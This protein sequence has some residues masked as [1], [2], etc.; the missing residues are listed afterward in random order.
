MR[1]IFFI[2]IT[3]ILVSSLN[4]AEMK[5]KLRSD[6]M[7]TQPQTIFKKNLESNLKLDLPPVAAN[8]PGSEMLKMWLVGVM[9]DVSFPT[10]DLGDAY[11]TGFSGH[12]M[13]GYMIARS[14]LLNLSV[15]YTSFS[16]KESVEG[17][18]I[19]FSWVPL[20]LGVNYVFNP[21]KKFMPFIG[22]ALGLYFISQ[23][24]SYSGFGQTFEADD[25]STEF[26]IV[27]RIGAYYVASASV[28]LALSLEYNII[29]TEGSSSSALGILFG[30][31]F[32]F[33]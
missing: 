9:A 14:V 21:D 11:S 23:S 31:M 18:D 17:A 1:Q 33:H 4:M 10:G 24:F 26:G 7:E 12:A 27:P 3:V 15:G 30:A 5:L 13:L 22:A 6:L 29:F 28:L 19:S 16:E 2:L 8:Q 32:A 25:T 20:L